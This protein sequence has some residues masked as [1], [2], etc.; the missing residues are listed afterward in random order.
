MALFKELFSDV[1]NTEEL[2]EA[3]SGAEV[4]SIKYE[5]KQRKIALRL[6]L[7][8]LINRESLYKRF[9]QGLTAPFLPCH[10]MTSL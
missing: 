8:K 1:L 3:F 5:Q 7:N 6:K 10:I 9:S 2:S 4:L